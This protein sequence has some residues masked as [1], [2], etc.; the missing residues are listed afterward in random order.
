MIKAPQHSHQ[1][2]SVPQNH[3]D[4][5][6]RRCVRGRGGGVRSDEKGEANK[7]TRAHGRDPP[8][9]PQT[10]RPPDPAVA[11][12]EP[13]LLITGYIPARPPAKNPP[14]TPPPPTLRPS[15]TPSATRRSHTHHTDARAAAPSPLDTL[16]STLTV[17]LLHERR[18]PREE[19]HRA[20][21]GMYVRWVA[22]A[23]RSLCVRVV[24]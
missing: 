19:I 10:P 7:S 21:S 8:R 3:E 9:G 17:Q 13:P 1:I 5:L 18:R 20:P 22:C 15:P 4:P 12:R 16:H 23:R 24:L 6:C 14:S 2:P 11:R